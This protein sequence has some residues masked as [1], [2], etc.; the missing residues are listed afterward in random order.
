MI[1][2]PDE[3]ELRLSARRRPFGWDP[4]A[5]LQRSPRAYIALVILA[6]SA[7]VAALVG[8]MLGSPAAMLAFAAAFPAFWLLQYHLFL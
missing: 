4:L 5:M 2:E 3:Q 7:V 8:G 6:P 1:H